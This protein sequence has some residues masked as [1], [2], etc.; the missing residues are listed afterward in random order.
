MKPFPFQ[1][2]VGATALLC[3]PA[4]HPVR[5]QGMETVNGIAA[6][7]GSSVITREQVQRTAFRAIQDY[8]DQY[9]TQPALFR[10]RVDT[11]LRESLDR[12]VE[13]RLILQEA[14]A[15]LLNIPESIIEDRVQAE[16]KQI[17]NDRA[18]LTRS[19]QEQGLT[20]EGFRREI[21]EQFI[22][23]V[24]RNRHVPRDILISPGRIERFY[25]DHEE[26]FRVLDQVRLRMIVL[27]R[28][29]NPVD[30]VV[31]G[32]EILAK[33]DEGADF[34]EMAAVYSDGSQ[35]REGGLWGWVDRKVLREDLA[36]L[37]FQLPAGRRS[38]LIEKPEAVYIMYVEEVRTAHIRPISEVRTEIERAL[39]DAERDRLAQQWLERLRKKAFVRYF[40]IIPTSQ[41]AIDPSGS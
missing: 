40:W 12:L 17:Y 29:R 13:R 38:D 28:T 31:L 2:L 22:E 9:A 10:Q 25:R 37:A 41:P 30:A 24:M 6:L 3:L 27:D 19:L 33:L 15:L 39:I 7:V 16:I 4:A 26:R 34:A 32:R 8:R 35:A 5:A 18:T 23:A 20:F 14:E 1:A 36:E 11:A 21:R